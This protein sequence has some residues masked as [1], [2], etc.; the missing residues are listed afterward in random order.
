MSY[1]E[2]MGWLNLARPEEREPSEVLLLVSG[3]LDEMKE[4]HPDYEALLDIEQELKEGR[5]PQ[6]LLAQLAAGA[7]ADEPLDEVDRLTREYHRLAAE[8]Q[9]E[10]WQSVYYLELST[11]LAESEDEELLDFI[12][13]LRRK[14]TQAWRK[15]S[16]DYALV[17]GVS[18]ETAVGHR[19]LEE[20][21]ASWME[22][23]QMLEEGF[24]TDEVLTTAEWAV[25]LL[26]A[27][28]HLNKEV[29][30][31]AASLGSKPT[32]RTGR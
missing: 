20:A 6:A 5:I 32:F 11:H 25:R 14:L 15:Y 30:R 1:Q 8:L 3:A 13:S 28:N 9:P 10:Q 27:V 18:A 29:Q 21:H 31:Q 17:P 26:A 2:L 23:L 22:A 12:D 16:R 19:L 4:D 24:A 7:A